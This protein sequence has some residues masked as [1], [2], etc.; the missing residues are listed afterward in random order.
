[1]EIL[2]QLGRIMCEHRGKDPDALN[3]NRE[4]WW[5]VYSRGYKLL[6]EAL[7]G[8]YDIIPTRIHEALKKECGL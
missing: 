7:Q 5:L 1:M 4:P 6:A 8:E 2:E 3:F